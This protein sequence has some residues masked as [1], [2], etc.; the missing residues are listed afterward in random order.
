MTA[1]LP[2][3]V[4]DFIDATNRFDIEGF[5]APFAHDA[6]INDRHRPFW[7]TDAIRK[8]SE[9]EM[10]GDHV[11]IEVRDVR[12]HYGDVIV[13]AK[14]DGDYDKSD[15]PP[16]LILAFYFTVRGDKI[17][18]IILMP[19]G[20]RKLSKATETSEAA[21]PYSAGVPAL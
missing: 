14:V 13:T 21:T 3:P 10:V 19:V 1:E 9:I 16:E 12:E 6:L 8:W 15:L 17:V 20:G 4:A 2:K 18:Q 7:G 11:T 5:M